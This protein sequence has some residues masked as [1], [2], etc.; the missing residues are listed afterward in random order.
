M[1]EVP[2]T[3]DLILEL[4]GQMPKE[5]DLSPSIST[6]YRSYGY[7]IFFRV[8]NIMKVDRLG[9]KV[10]ITENYFFKKKYPSLTMDCKDF[11][12]VFETYELLLSHLCN[13]ELCTKRKKW[14]ILLR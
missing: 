4:A 13:A 5:S 1:Y 14:V 6:V 2:L 11:K 7:D 12:E 9:M 3:K 8:M 10:Q